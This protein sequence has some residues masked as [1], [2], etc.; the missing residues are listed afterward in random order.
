MEPFP[1][2]LGINPGEEEDRP[3]L[4]CGIPKLELL[5]AGEGKDLEDEELKA[6]LCK[7]SRSD[8][9]NRGHD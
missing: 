9:Q 7:S 4:A 3:C 8:L 5:W 1:L 2:I 6:L